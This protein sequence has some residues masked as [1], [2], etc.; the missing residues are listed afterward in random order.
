MKYF[1]V[2]DGVMVFP[3]LSMYPLI[4]SSYFLSMLSVVFC[5]ILTI[6]SFCLITSYFKSTNSILSLTQ[7]E[8]LTYL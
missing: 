2:K 4:S 6:F 8:L 3:V 5:L 1:F 7:N